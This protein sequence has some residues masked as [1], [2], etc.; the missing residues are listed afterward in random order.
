LIV[1]ANE[2]N[3]QHSKLVEKHSAWLASNLLCGDACKNGTSLGAMRDPVKFT[4]KRV[5]RPRLEAQH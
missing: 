1:G 2:N 4:A 5:E 3:L